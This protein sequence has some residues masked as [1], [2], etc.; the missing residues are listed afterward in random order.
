LRYWLDLTD[1][2]IALVMD[3]PV[4]TVKSTLPRGLAR[5]RQADAGG[6]GRG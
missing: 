5:L 4:G 1:T 3:C 6:E 2:Q